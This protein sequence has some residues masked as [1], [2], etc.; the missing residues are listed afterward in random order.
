MAGAITWY[1]CTGSLYGNWLPGDP[2][3]W[4]SRNHRI[5]VEGDYQTPPEAGRFT[6]IH[7]RS[8][9]LLKHPPMWLALDQRETICRAWAEGIE[10][11]ALAGGA[12]AIGS[13]HWHLLFG[14]CDGQP[15]V[16]IGRLKSWSLKRLQGYGRCPAG[17][18]WAAGSRAEPI[19]DTS[20]WWNAKRYIERHRKQGAAVWAHDR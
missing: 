19:R 12:I 13:R 8:A 15:C 9:A 4:R 20:H 6:H 17:K 7:R 10:H 2:R 5:H 1:H 16:W 14:C 11:Y 18:V 3:G